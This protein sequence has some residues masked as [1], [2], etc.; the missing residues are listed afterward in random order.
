MKLHQVRAFLAVSQTG[1]LKAAAEQLHLTQPAL[2]KA[3]KELEQQ[4]GV[5]L[6]E[7]SA[8]GLTL[9][10]YGER[11]MGY[12]RLMNETA[13]RAKQEIDTMRGV[14]NGSVTI[15]VTPVASL[16]KS[17]ASSLNTFMQRYPEV[18]LRIVELRPAPLLTHLRQ[19]EVDF[20]IT[21]QIP[22]I[23]SALEWQAVCRIPN[24]VVTRKSHPLCNTRSLRTLHQSDWLTL[25]SPDDPSTYFYQLFS[26][27]GL[28]LPSRI[29]ECTSMTLARSLIQNADFAALFSTESLDLDYIKNEF[30][31][32]PLL[33]NIPDSVISVV[34]PKRD[35]MTQ[36]ATALFDGIL[37]DMR[38]IYPDF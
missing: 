24:V 5:A 11:L 20:A 10:P 22:V 35:I 17:L 14:P 31:V 13:R 23:D 26:V 25:D 3:I 34:R 6:F 38:D 33:D 15:G 1:S 7:R 27:N 12:A 21:S 32:V 2:S 36:S 4:Y 37:Q 18:S 30:A 29:R 16:L 28:T 19:G 9:T 8:G